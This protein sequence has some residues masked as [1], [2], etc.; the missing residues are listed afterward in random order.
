MRISGKK[1]LAAIALAVL[2]TAG[3]AVR[4]SA[5]E[6]VCRIGDTGYPSIAQALDAAVS[7]DVI[8][9]TGD[10]SITSR[11]VLSGKSVT[12][13]DDGTPRVIQISN[14]D[15]TSPSYGR[16]LQLNSGASLSI[17]AGSPGAI[18]I[19]GTGNAGTGI[20]VYNGSISMTNA[21]LCGFD[22]SLTGAKTS[23]GGALGVGYKDTA[24]STGEAVLTDCVFY[25]NSSADGDDIFVSGT[26][27][28]TVNGLECGCISVAQGGS[29]QL[30]GRVRALISSYGPVSL[31]QGFSAESSV[32]LERGGAS[33]GLVMVTGDA[34][35][36]AACR[37]A[38]TIEDGT[39]AL[40]GEGKAVL[41]HFEA[42]LGS[43]SD[44]DGSYTYPDA[45]AEAV[46]FAPDSVSISVSSGTFAIDG[47]RGAAL[48]ETMRAVSSSYAYSVSAGSFCGEPCIAASLEYGRGLDAAEA[49]TLLRS[50]IFYPE[51]D[52]YPQKVSIS[53]DTRGAG[54]LLAGALYS[55]DDRQMT[56]ESALGAGLACISDRQ[57]NALI[58]GRFSA[59][60]WI[61]AQQMSGSWY[62]NSGSLKG[63]RLSVGSGNDQGYG[64]A[65]VNWAD[66]E[67]AGGIF[68]CL[69]PDGAWASAGS[70]DTKGA[71]RV[72]EAFFS[73]EKTH[74]LA[75]TD[76][77]VLSSMKLSPD[78]D[79]SVIYYFS[80][81][82]TFLADSANYAVVT[83]GEGAD[84]VETRATV[85]EMSAE[86]SSAG[87]YGIRVSFP[88]K[89]MG[90]NVSMKLFRSSGTLVRSFG[91][92]DGTRPEKNFNPLYF[93][94][95]VLDENTDRHNS[96]YSETYRSMI[97]AMLL[98]G[99]AAQ[100]RFD[101]NTDSLVD[102]GIDTQPLPAAS[103]IENAY[104]SASGDV[105]WTGASLEAAPLTVMHV[106]F[107]SAAAVDSVAV[108]G[109]EVGFSADGGNC[110]VDI[111][112]S[113]AE[114]D[115]VY[116]VKVRSGDSVSTLLINADYVIKQILV[117]SEDA[118]ARECAGA[119]Y[120]LGKTADAY[121]GYEAARYDGVSAAVEIAYAF[122]NK[123]EYTQYD[124]KFS[125]QGSST[126]YV[127]AGVPAG[128]RQLESVPE[129]A[130]ENRD[131]YLD[132]S[133]F[134]YS[135]YAA[136][137]G[138][139]I[140]MEAFLDQEYRSLPN[141]K[142]KNMTQN[143]NDAA[144]VKLYT[145]LASDTW[146]SD[147][148]SAACIAVWKEVVADAKALMQPGDMLVYYGYD[149]S[150][151][152]GGH[153]VFYTGRGFIESTGSSYDTEN[154]VDKVDKNGS[155]RFVSTSQFD[156][157]YLQKH[158]ASQARII[159]PSLI[160]K[161]AV[162]DYARARADLG[163]LGLTVT[164]SDET[165][166]TSAGMGGSAIGGD[167]LVF[168]LRLDNKAMTGYES[169]DRLADIAMT[170]PDGVSIISAGDGTADGQTVTWRGVSV[171]SGG[172]CSLSVRANVTGSAGTYLEGA[173][174]TVSPAGDASRSITC[175]GEDIMIE[176]AVSAESLSRLAALKN[177]FASYSFDPSAT[178]G[179][180]VVNG[181]MT[182]VKGETV[183]LGASGSALLQKY[184]TGSS[185]YRHRYQSKSAYP[186]LVDNMASG[187]AVY[188]PSFSDGDFSYTE[189]NRAVR[190]DSLKSG[191]ILMICSG[192]DFEYYI[193]LDE[194][195]MMLVGSDGACSLAQTSAACQKAFGSKVYIVMRTLGR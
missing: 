6:A 7:G 92:F 28:L 182:S 103:D 34:E 8:V 121:Y 146:Y 172:S 124:N 29:A 35:T 53:F 180:A 194:N 94:K 144:T 160:G 88:A 71:Y 155:V 149:K 41:R 130:S 113:A 85:T 102:D 4:A 175:S 27:E 38:F 93:A 96:R 136:V 114:L 13:T 179:L 111:A 43:P 109:S 107:R 17:T 170:L 122:L 129:M 99:G 77:S 158:G 133:S 90:D 16:G 120:R 14:S 54:G 185:V 44:G 55:F 137:Y 171:K 173:V 176:K 19:D 40:S 84:A 187:K 154:L 79:I 26:S 75:V 132:C 161:D 42:E 123:K 74:S 80:L 65:F 142:T 166:G 195:E 9:L 135:V 86:R 21:V 156:Y 140:A 58:A 89:R 97:K 33:E 164:V 152:A 162:T 168:T 49:E 110:G 60:G 151:S 189:R 61:G 30:G 126:T 191:D 127:P 69:S 68:A 193:S 82:P 138:R 100:R 56:F 10:V 131:L 125:T 116:A 1:I 12:I 118:Q 70:Q 81:D 45:K 181:I 167:T 47:S 24:A 150:G 37:G 39:Y 117:Q 98:Y 51:S 67:P 87:F 188:I 134:C 143:G 112:V 192:T 64:G 169:E 5:D 165:Q 177:S 63:T 73:M 50:I 23:A 148:D 115:R 104:F 2:L 157:T 78:G 31:I 141:L 57:T 119:L 46:S 72:R 25:D 105:V 59:E 159:R 108:D 106:S 186:L 36:I 174:C 128:R 3:A 18:T 147:G 66:G 163:A 183:D 48:P 178:D 76:H 139:D 20:L 22:N 190:E 83:V 32:V 145:D 184:F 52:G 153:I 95:Y 15:R 11:C 62:W 91:N 101:W